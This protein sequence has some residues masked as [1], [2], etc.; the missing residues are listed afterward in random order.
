MLLDL[1]KL[2]A[3]QI[4]KE[5]SLSEISQHVLI[6]VKT[7]KRYTDLLVKSYVI[8]P[9]TPFSKNLRSEISGKNKYYFYDTGVRNGI[10]NNFNRL[11]SRNDVGALLE[12]CI[13]AEILKK[14]K[15]HETFTNLY[16]WRTYT[17][18]KLT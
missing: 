15:I 2:L 8:F 16:F 11:Y 14:T 10:I 7:V 18:G 9:L 13:I 5:V 6:D 4:E 12:N 1:L 3:S 17:K